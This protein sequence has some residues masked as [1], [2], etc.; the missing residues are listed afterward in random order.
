MANWVG[1]LVSLVKRCAPH[2]LLAVKLVNA[3]LSQ[4]AVVATAVVPFGELFV[5]VGDI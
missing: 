3:K 2:E 5:L 4:Y 1:K